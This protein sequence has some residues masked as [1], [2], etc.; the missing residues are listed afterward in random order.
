MRLKRIQTISLL[1]N[2]M[3]QAWPGKIFWWLPNPRKFCCCQAGHQVNHQ[4][5]GFEDQ[6]SSW[7]SWWSHLAPL[8][9]TSLNLSWPQIPLH[10]HDW[11]RSHGKDMLCRVGQIEC[12]TWTAWG[13]MHMSLAHYP[14]THVGRGSAFC[15]RI[16]AY[17]RLLHI[18]SLW[19]WG[20]EW[21]HK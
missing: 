3:Q 18:S 1:R 21:H 17:P 7:L 14:F 2:W 4:V 6:L 9:L 20:R 5:A 12:G 13:G 15:A 10:I 16:D 19:V 11:P 8:N